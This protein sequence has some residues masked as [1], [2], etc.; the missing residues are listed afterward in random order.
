MDTWSSK[1]YFH[2]VTKYSLLPFFQPRWRGCWS[3]NNLVGSVS[4]QNITFLFFNF[5]FF[6]LHWSCRFLWPEIIKMS[7]NTLLS[8]IR[9][10][11][12]IWEWFKTKMCQINKKY[13]CW[14]LGWHRPR[15]QTAAIFCRQNAGVWRVK[16]PPAAPAFCRWFSK[17]DSAGGFRI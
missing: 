4:A 13:M 1:R 11:H 6:F 16:N 17:W 3:K 8:M 9:E 14:N 10:K 5:R 7:G 2:R 15:R 12:K